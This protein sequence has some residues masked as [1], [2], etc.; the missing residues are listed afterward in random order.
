MELLGKVLITKETLPKNLYMSSLLLLLLNFKL[1][2][3]FAL[4]IIVLLFNLDFFFLKYQSRY[5]TNYYYLWFMLSEDLGMWISDMN[6]YV[7]MWNEIACDVDEI[8]MRWCWCHWDECMLR[9]YMGVQ[10]PCLNIPGEEKGL[11]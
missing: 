6:L 3:E 10:W 5:I 7:Y 1:A 9:M 4:Y 11:V 2:W 8:E